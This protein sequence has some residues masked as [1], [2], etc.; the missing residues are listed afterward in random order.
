MVWASWDTSFDHSGADMES[1]IE[2]LNSTRAPETFTGEHARAYELAEWCLDH[3]S[4]EHA[5]ARV[6]AARELVDIAYRRH[7]AG[8]VSAGYFMLLVGLLEQGEI[9]TLDIELM[10]Q[11]TGADRLA[12]TVNPSLWFH[13]QRSILDGDAELAEEQANQLYAATS[14]TDPQAMALYTTQITMIR[15]MQG[16]LDGIEDRFLAAR[17]HHPDQL[18][19]PASLVWLWTVQGRRETAEALLRS[20]PRPGAIRRDNQWL[21]TIT[22]LAEIAAISGPREDAERLQHLLEPFAD[23]LVPVGTGA[24]WGTVA[25][26]LG[27]LEERL[28][29]LEAARAHLELAI[30]TSA[31]IGALAWHAEAQ[32]ELAEFA[33]RHDLADIPAYDLLAEAKATSEARSFPA[34][35]RRAMHRPCI[36]VLGRFE[37]ISLGGGLAV[38][39]SR[40]ARELLKM[41]VASRGVARSREEFMDV[42]WPGEPPA[43]LGNRF[44]VTI[45]VIRRAL[46]PDRLMPTQHFLV[47]EGD[48]V[49]LATAHLTI[50]LE[51]FFSLAE[52]PGDSSRRAAQ[53][54]YRGAAF[55]D[56]PYADWAVSVRARADH[57]HRQLGD[58]Q[59]RG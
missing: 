20:L 7:D 34:L 27:L 45:N 42:L 10:E 19:W 41:L 13:C 22:V 12:D 30:V 49:R 18:V 47:T 38:W 59:P 2:R 32:I 53:R 9:R 50:D 57:V 6:E 52:Q 16:R 39:T 51:R 33:I 44:S 54:L 8:L 17:R 21:A 24:F 1:L 25:R 31:R 26:T 28:G 56:E 37:V 14:D 4:P 3:L 36:N 23:R 11:R 40:K 55:S 46:D 43:A 5:A 15:W 35:A 58:A 48:S 29:M